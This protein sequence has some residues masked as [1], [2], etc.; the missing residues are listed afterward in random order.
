MNSATAYGWDGI[1]RSL[2]GMA[3]DVRNSKLIPSSYSCRFARASFGNIRKISR[4]SREIKQRARSSREDGRGSR[5]EGTGAR[6]AGVSPRKRRRR[7]GGG[8]LLG[9]AVGE[10]EQNYV[11]NYYYEEIIGTRMH[12]SRMRTARSLPYGWGSPWQRPPSGHR[13]PPPT[14]R[15]ITRGQTNTCENITFANFVCGR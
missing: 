10:N 12:S 8:V 4:G 5:G 13:P 3:A 15:D 11:G 1:R 14:D 9:T 6:E 7:R 2:V